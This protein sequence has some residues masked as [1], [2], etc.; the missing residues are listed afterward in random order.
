MRDWKMRDWNYRHHITGGGN[1]GQELSGTGNVWN[2]TC[3]MSLGPVAVQCN[4][5]RG[6]SSHS[7]GGYSPPETNVLPPLR[8]D[9]N[10]PLRGG[11]PVL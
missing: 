1:C 9:I 6:L 2:A 8:E 10:S 5:C 3:D 7:V 11:V 4:E